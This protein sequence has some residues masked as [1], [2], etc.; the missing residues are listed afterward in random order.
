V[1]YFLEWGGG[2]IAPATVAFLLVPGFV[3][4]ALVVVL[5][6]LAVVVV[7]VAAA[8][9]AT[10]YLLGSFVRRRWQARSAHRQR[11]ADDSSTA[12]GVA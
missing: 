11:P 10:P 3:L 4:I 9:V 2:F 7:A 8:I 1:S 12:S 5:I 6:V